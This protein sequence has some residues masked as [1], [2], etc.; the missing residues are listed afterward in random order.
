MHKKSQKKATGSARAAISS[1]A[2]T[3]YKADPIQTRKLR[4]MNTVQVPGSYTVTIGDLFRTYLLWDTTDLMPLYAG[5]RIRRIQVWSL[6]VTSSNL[7]TSISLEWLSANAPSTEISRSGDQAHP[8]YITTQ[9]PD[10]SLAGFWYSYQNSTLTTP[11]F[12]LN[13]N[14]SEIVD[15]EIEYVPASGFYSTFLPTTNL[16]LPGGRGVFYGPLSATSP[17]VRL[18]AV[19][20]PI[21]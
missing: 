20:N 9:P 4:F 13:L 18:A 2:P 1:Q 12:L 7:F 16:S 5:I 8:A 15:V 19:S 21:V 3:A 10:G 14:G 6:N 17:T 11:L